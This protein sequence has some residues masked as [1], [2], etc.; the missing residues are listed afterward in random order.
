MLCSNHVLEAAHLMKACNNVNRG[1]DMSG[2]EEDPVN[3]VCNGIINRI[4]RHDEV[5]I[6]CTFHQDNDNDTPT[7]ITWYTI[8]S[9]VNANMNV[10]VEVQA[11]QEIG[12]L[13]SSSLNENEQPFYILN[14]K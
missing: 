8:C 10:G 7:T 12:Q 1:I 9:N 3:A 5:I 6:E 4:T 11:G 14:Y 13:M 2:F